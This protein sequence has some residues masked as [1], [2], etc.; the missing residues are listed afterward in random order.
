VQFDH[1][2]L[3]LLTVGLSAVSWQ[4]WFRRTLP[5][6]RP[7]SRPL[8]GPWLMF[9]IVAALGTLLQLRG[10]ALVYEWIPGAAFIQFPWR[11]LALITPA[12]I[13]AAVYLADRTLG[14]DTRAFV[15]GGTLA[16]MVAACG[17]FEP[18]RDSRISLSPQLSS[19][20]FSGFREYEPRVALPVAEIHQKLTARWAEAGCSH[21]RMESTG[22]EDPA[23]TF[24]TSCGRAVVLP[25]PLYASPLHLVSTTS[26]RRSQSCLALPDFPAICAAVIPAGDSVLTVR[27]PTMMSIV[28]WGWRR[29]V[30]RPASAATAA[31]HGSDYEVP[32]TKD[33]KGRRS[34]YLTSMK[35]GFE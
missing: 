6:E 11:L 25:L 13:V 28:G 1:A 23:A 7:P 5:S 2:L 21:A 16:W 18:L 33:T 30:A 8:H 22:T 34:L 3:A 31:A 10:S 24:R 17:A 20:T 27:M 32:T 19:I 9:L 29:L 4:A 26:H 14:A 12:L 15:L 35:I